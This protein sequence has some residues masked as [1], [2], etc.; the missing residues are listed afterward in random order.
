[1]VNFPRNAL[2]AF[3]IMALL[4][5]PPIALSAAG[6]DQALPQNTEVIL[7]LRPQLISDDA[8]FSNLLSQSQLVGHYLDLLDIS[9]KQVEYAAMFM[10]YDPAW[11]DNASH[12]AYDNLP[13]PA[14]MIIKGAFDPSAKY[15]QVKSSGWREDKHANKK[16]L[17]WSTGETYLRNATGR[18]YLAK[19]G[20]DRLLIAGSEDS[21]KG[22]L[23]VVGDKMTGIESMGVFQ[24]I[25][26]AFFENDQVMASAFIKVNEDLRQMIKDDIGEQQSAMI[27]TAIGYVDNVDETALSIIRGSGNYLLEGYLGMDS[28][29]NAMVVTSVLQAGG[30][31]A[32]LLPRNAP[33]HAALENLTV[34][35]TERIVKVQSFMA[36]AQ[37]NDLLGS[38][39]R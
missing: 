24:D 15:R 22:V 26:L 8:Q 4:T 1:M 25:S 5:F 10:P 17:W 21:M 2:I 13:A 34:T 11:M 23:D 36:H 28:G 16:L 32:G 6:L 27:R 12:G 35:R 29:N 33:G 19:L 18:E 14:A 3:A 9:L 37:L 39:V 31:L 7:W 30:S 20:N 38:S